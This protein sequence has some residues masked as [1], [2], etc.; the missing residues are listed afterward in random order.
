MVSGPSRQEDRGHVKRDS[1]D[2]V[3][4]PPPHDA[5][6]AVLPIT[7]SVLNCVIASRI[8]LV[9]FASSGV[10]F[11]CDLKEGSNGTNKEPSGGCDCSTV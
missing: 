6:A 8:A 2:S 4:G 10:A 1:L 9:G 3:A 5:A 7:C 11:P